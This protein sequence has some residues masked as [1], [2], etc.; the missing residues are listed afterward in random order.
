MATT[1]RATAGYATRLSSRIA[2]VLAVW[3]PVADTFR[4]PLMS[5]VASGFGHGFDQCQFTATDAPMPT[6]DRPSLFTRRLGLIFDTLRIRDTARA[7]G[8]FG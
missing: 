3:L 1:D 6:S 7:C 2:S 8:D 5:I 4:L